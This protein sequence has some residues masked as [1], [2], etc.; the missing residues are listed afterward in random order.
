MINK[1]EK[2]TPAKGLLIKYQGEFDLEKLYK[3]CKDW[4]NSKE[5]DFTEKEHTEKEKN[6][7][8]ELLI[9]FIGEREVDDYVKFEIETFFFILEIKKK[10]KRET[11]K[12]KI[13]VEAKRILDY[14][15]KWQG[16]A[17]N[18]FLFFVYNNYIIKNKIE[19][20]YEDKL[21]NELMEYTGMIKG[22]LG[23]Q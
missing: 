4:F 12:V 9:K 7:G 5:Y 21:F 23:L 11:A 3:S 18:K 22:V 6:Y 16:N 17:F 1:K 15:D 10:G 20:V 13:N 8:N 19:K 14:K 2:I